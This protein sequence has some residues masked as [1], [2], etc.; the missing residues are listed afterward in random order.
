MVGLLMWGGGVAAA[1]AAAAAA[2]SLQS[3]PTL[4]DPID[5]SLLGSSVPGILQARTLEWVAI[6]FS[7]G[8]ARQVISPLPDQEIRDSER[9]HQ[10]SQE[11]LSVTQAGVTQA[12]VLG[13]PP[14]AA[15]GDSRASLLC[16]PRRP[17][18]PAHM[19]GEQTPRWRLPG[20]HSALP[21]LCFLPLGVNPN[22]AAMASLLTFILQISE[23]QGLIPPWE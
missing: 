17:D 6:S 5:G 12:S 21:T 19:S 22:T 3:C 23:S 4:C 1:A 7:R 10:S 14:H 8:V 2:K 9:S 11:W 13:S 16:S 20:C 15:G 18:F